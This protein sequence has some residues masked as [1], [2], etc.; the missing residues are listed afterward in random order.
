MCC[1]TGE[2]RKRL[3]EASRLRASVRTV[4]SGYYDREAKRQRDRLAKAQKDR[5]GYEQKAAKAD[6]EATKLES[7]AT[8]TKSESMARSYLQRAE[9]KRKDAIN[10]RDRAAK[11][12]G[13]A[14]TAQ[15]NLGEAETKAS[16][17]RAKEEKK[18]TQDRE[19]QRKK[20]EQAERREQQRRAAAEQTQSLEI[21]ELRDRT[22]E[23][24]T[25]LRA[26]RR[27]APRRITVLFLAGTPEGAKEPLR[28]DREIREVDQRVRASEFRDQIAIEHA[29]AT[30]VSD[31][32]DAL[33]RYDPDVVH[34]SGH[35]DRATLLFEGADGRPH[36][37]RGEELAL[38][39][40]VAKKPIRLAIFN[41][42]DSADQALMA[43]DYVE[44]A[45]GMN[46][47]IGDDAAKVFAGQFYS[48]LG[49]GNSVQVAFDQAAAQLVVVGD[50]SGAPQLFNADGKE[51]A[52]MVLV[53]PPEQ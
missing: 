1:S 34:F 31:I 40:Q 17:A 4:D 19:R 26:A 28:L 8:R 33:N 36:A 12:S 37:L 5:A 32:I 15:K 18:A 14:A 6:S 11:A 13:D 39:L 41:A 22:R 9:R 49:A 7:Q 16:A 35:G 27:A 47:P 29:M 20:A 10:L 44:A 50:A 25:L 53:A 51:P 30:Q 38:L 45:I 21:G 24:E 48:S 3:C 43:T 46:E 52:E 23:L 42:C 2:S